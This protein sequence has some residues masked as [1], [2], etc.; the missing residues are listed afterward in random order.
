M[1]RIILEIRFHI[2]QLNDHRQ[3]L[4]MRLKYLLSVIIRRCSCGHGR[5]YLDKSSCEY[6]DE[7]SN[8]YFCCK[9]CHDEI[10]DHYEEMWNEYNSERL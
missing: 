1:K 2:R 8:Y 10:D 9:E 5:A 3:P 7:L 6:V 4:S